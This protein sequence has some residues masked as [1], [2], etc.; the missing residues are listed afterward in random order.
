MQIKGLPYDKFSAPV[1]E[2]FVLQTAVLSGD[3]SKELRI[4]ATVDIPVQ[5][6]IVLT[7][8]L[9]GLMNKYQQHWDG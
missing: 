9:C 2:D 1:M 7:Q 5:Q 6:E 8:H 3:G 4:F